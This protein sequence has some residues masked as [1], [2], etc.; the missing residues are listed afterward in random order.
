MEIPEVELILSQNFAKESKVF[1]LPFTRIALSE[2][3]GENT[4]FQL[5]RNR[6]HEF[7]F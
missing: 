3:I 2:N 6:L 7:A 4:A 5:D 1:T